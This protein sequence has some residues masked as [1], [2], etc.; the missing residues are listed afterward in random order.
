MAFLSFLGRH[1]GES[2][3]AFQ[4]RNISGEWHQICV[5]IEEEAAINCHEWHILCVFYYVVESKILNC[6]QYDEVQSRGQMRI[7][8]LQPF[9]RRTTKPRLTIFCCE[10]VMWMISDLCIFRYQYVMLL[11]LLRVNTMSSRQRTTTRARKIELSHSRRLQS[12]ARWSSKRRL[13]Y[14]SLS[15]VMWIRTNPNW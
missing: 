6:I 8:R 4:W 7:E 1:F 2:I 12:F 3:V 13:T 9:A 14:F 5:A 10:Y 11:L 15:V